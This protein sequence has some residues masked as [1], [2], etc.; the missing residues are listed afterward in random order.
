M[1]FSRVCIQICGVVVVQLSV[2][3]LDIEYVWHINFSEEDMLVMS[4]Y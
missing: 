3:F 4:C 1:E 2:I